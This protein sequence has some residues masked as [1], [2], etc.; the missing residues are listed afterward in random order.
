MFASLVEDPPVPKD[1]ATAAIRRARA[2]HRHRMALGSAA[3]I[4]SFLAFSGVLIWVQD[5]RTGELSGTYGMGD[6]PSQRSAPAPAE[7]TTA[8]PVPEPLRIAV[9]LLAGGQL[10]TADGQRLTIG[11]N[12]ELT[13]AYRVPVGWLV[14]GP[15]QSLLLR[16][17]GTTV[18]LKVGDNW[19][20][21]ADGSRIA[22][23]TGS[24]VRV[25]TVD[26]GGVTEVAVTTADVS[27]VPVTFAGDT[28]VIAAVGAAG[29]LEKLG[30]WR[31]PGPYRPTWT[32]QVLQVYDAPGPD[33]VG[34]VPSKAGMC[35]ARMAADSAGLRVS[36][37]GAC[38]I[39]LR[40]A[41]VSPDGGWLAVPEADVV[42][43]YDLRTVFAKPTAAARCGVANATDVVWED[44][45]RLL[46]AHNGGAVRCRTDG[47]LEPATLPA[48]LPVPWRFVPAR[49][50][51]SV[52]ARPTA[53]ASAAVPG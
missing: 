6:L 34:L 48:G 52:L 22:Y 41:A 50:Q 39:P 46:V 37:V 38:G 26:S 43:V 9:D 20:V 36:A 3:A 24:T 40:P 4:V 7:P 17:D 5:W 32:Q 27:A 8:A 51:I 18:P 28:V 10:W 49:E 45:T 23:T 53:E 33:L 35:L 14:G 13:R 11:A 47:S 1:P 19:V 21:S 29:K 30:Q 44:A 25:A 12:G 2:I 15:G 16:P 31:P 42:T